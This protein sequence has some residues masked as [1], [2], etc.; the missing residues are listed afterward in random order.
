MARPDEEDDVLPEINKRL[1]LNLLIQGAAAHSFLT[2]HHLVKEELESIQPGLTHLYD[3]FAICGLLNYFIGDIV[4]IYGTPSRFWRDTRNSSHPFR[5]HR[6][7]AE[8]GRELAYASKKHLIERGKKK[9]VLYVPFLQQVQM[10]SLG[11]RLAMAER[12]HHA[13]LKELAKRATSIIW[14]IEEDRLEAEFTTEV[15]FGNLRTPK[16][17]VGRITAKGAIGYGGV[18]RRDGRFVVVAKSW[19]WPLIVHELIKG[20]AELVCLHGLNA[21]DDSTYDQVMDEADQIEF[22]TW[23]LQAGSEAWRRLLAVLPKDRRLPEMLMH[24]ARLDPKFLE[25]LML[26]VASDPPRAKRLIGEL[27]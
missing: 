27:G 21:L 5:R 3:R 18:V 10:Y 1:T 6:L 19:F 26:A 13:R 14:G 25:V 17:A 22:E 24:I 9:G 16:T 23:M 12:H 7:L 8:Y 4:L 11:S 2:A 20:T 15:R